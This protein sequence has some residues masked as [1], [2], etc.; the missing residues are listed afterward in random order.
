MSKVC[1]NDA[2]LLAVKKDAWSWQTVKMAGALPTPREGASA[3]LL[4][5]NKE[6]DDPS[7]LVFGGGLLDAV[8]Y[9]DL[10]VAEVRGI[11]GLMSS[12]VHCLPSVGFLFSRCPSLAKHQRKQYLRQVRLLGR[13]PQ[14]LPGVLQKLPVVL[15]KL[16]GVLPEQLLPT[17][18]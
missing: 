1:F 10:F 5:P 15:Q 12:V 2:N 4:P 16:L 7:V 8:T 14:G 18:L 13:L 3:T 11:C 17:P 9:N 6:G